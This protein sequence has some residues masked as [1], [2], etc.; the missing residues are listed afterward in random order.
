MVLGL[1][2]SVGAASAAPTLTYRDLLNKLVD[3]NGLP[4]L[5]AG[6]RCAQASSYDRASHDPA[7]WQANGDSGQYLAVAENGEALMADLKGPGCIFR[8][9][10]ANPQ[11]TIRFYLD[12]DTKP[13]YEFDFHRM[14]LGEFGPQRVPAPIVYKRDPKN[15][16]SAS[17][18]YLPIPYQKSCRVTADKRHGQYY[19]I[20]YKT[21]PPDTQVPTFRLPLSAEEQQKLAAVAAAWSKLGEQPQEPVSAAQSQS[22]HVDLGPGEKQTLPALPGP[23]T[24]CGLRVAANGEERY[25]LRNLMLRIYWDGGRTP[26]VCT[27][28]GDFFGGAWEATDYRALPL[29]WTPQG[30]YCYFRMPFRSEAVFEL[31]NQGRKPVSLDGSVDYV[32]GPVPDSYGYFHAGWRREA[33][34][35]QFDY[36]ILRAGGSGKFVGVMLSIEHPVPGWWGEGDEKIWVDGEDFPS[37]FGTGSE[38]YFGDAWGIRNDLRQPYFGDN[39][40]KGPRSCCYR[41]HISDSVPFSRAYKMVIENYDPG[42]DDY[43]TVAYWYA[44]PGSTDFFAEVPAAE[45]R[46]WSRSVAGAAQVEM[47]FAAALPPSAKLIADA[48][49]AFELGEGGGLALTASKPGETLG[50]GTFTVPAEGVYLLHLVGEPG[51]PLRE[52]TAALDGKP[53]PAQGELVP[54][55]TAVFGPRQLAAGEHS[56]QLGFK[57]ETTGL[58]DYLALVRTRSEHTYEAES[59]EI[60]EVK[61]PRPGPQAMGYSGGVL[62][63]QQ[64]S[65]LFFTPPSQEASLTLVLDVPAAGAYRLTWYASKS[66]DYAIYQA[67]LDGKPLGEPVDLYAPQWEV[68]GAE[69][70]VPVDLTAGKHLLRFA[71][72]GKNENSKGYYF[73]LDALTLDPR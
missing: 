17:D 7:R 4:D 66:H 10:S 3:L 68:A 22:V 50:P 8:I 32:S 27:P 70:A 59:L 24:I 20:G 12:G 40:E 57:A 38:D 46:P 42:V 47:M 23:A 13:T 73:G 16:N 35:K 39:Y 9:W 58:L 25:Y 67:E 37:T 56:L 44:A 48:D 15:A 18:C 6:V 21:Y 64:G 28:L 2:L 30:A 34:C 41:F 71:P 51:K 26:A 11:G 65:Q 52:L 1:L 33:P 72:V 55:G 29:G 43:A 14:F 19:H 5:E 60:A 31:E 53:L 61:G 62:A 45:R 69:T 54:T 63:G 36:S 49:L